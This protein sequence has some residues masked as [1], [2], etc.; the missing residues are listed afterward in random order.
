MDLHAVYEDL[1]LI[2]NAYGEVAYQL[3][4]SHVPEIDATYISF[5]TVDRTRYSKAYRFLEKI[6]GPWFED[7]MLTLIGSKLFLDIE[8]YRNYDRLR[9]RLQ[10][11]L[12]AG[13]TVLESLI[14]AIADEIREVRN[15]LRTSSS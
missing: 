13:E 8:E 14:A 9:L 10:D 6:Y 3:V 11:P 1:V 5:N 4:F 15:E 7:N 12:P 2:N